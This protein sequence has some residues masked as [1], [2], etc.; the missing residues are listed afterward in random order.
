MF[1]KCEGCLA[2][3]SRLRVPAA[4]RRRWLRPA[5]AVF[6][7]TWCAGCAEWGKWAECERW[8]GGILEKQKLGK[9]RAEIGGRRTGG[10]GR[11]QGQSN[12]QSSGLKLTGEGLVQA[13]FKMP[14]FKSR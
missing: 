8:G 13:R 5:P 12:Y 14:I 2:Q 6:A 11:T 7:D 1:K 3:A 4:P 10:K 9:Q